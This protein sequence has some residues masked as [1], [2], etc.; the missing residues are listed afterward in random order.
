MLEAIRIPDYA[1]E[2]GPQYGAAAKIMK[3]MLPPRQKVDWVIVSGE[4][5]SNPRPM[6]PDWARTLRD[7]CA[8]AGVPF[9]MKQMSGRTKAE[10]QAIPNDLMVRERP[11]GV[12]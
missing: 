12:V 4:S 3:M 6:N 9:F 7:Q 2:G 1:L 11:M 10:K 8:A 5:G